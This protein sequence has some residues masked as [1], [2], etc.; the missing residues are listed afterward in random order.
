MCIYTC[1]NTRYNKHNKDANRT[2]MEACREGPHECRWCSTK[3]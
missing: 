3:A 1:S 2:G